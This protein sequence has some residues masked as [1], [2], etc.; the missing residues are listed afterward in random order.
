MLCE[1]HTGNLLTGLVALLSCSWTYA[2]IG[3]H[4]VRR[5]PHALQHPEYGP[6]FAGY[7][8]DEYRQTN[9][10][11]MDMVDQWSDDITPL[12]TEKHCH[13]FWMCSQYELQ[14]WDMAYSADQ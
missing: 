5:Y 7:V 12:E 6:W 11:L 9:Q 10:E 3:E 8:C 2:Y 13:L 1:A 4:M 14:Y